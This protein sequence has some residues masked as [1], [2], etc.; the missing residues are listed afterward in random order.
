M[1]LVGAINNISLVLPPYPPLTQPG[2]IDESQFCDSLNRPASCAGLQVC[3]CTHRLKVKLN[4]VVEL[5]LVDVTESKFHLKINV[6][7]NQ[8]CFWF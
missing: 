6:T 4:S 2:L 5:I 3:H 7:V 1:T 8:K